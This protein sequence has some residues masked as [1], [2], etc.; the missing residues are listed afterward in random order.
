MDVFSP[1]WYALIV[2]GPEN[3]QGTIWNLQDSS[4]A[5]K[6]LQVWYNVT[7]LHRPLGTLKHNMYIVFIVITLTPLHSSQRQPGLLK[8]RPYTR[9]TL[10]TF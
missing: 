10:T 1:F 5:A 8:T 2:Y 9:L 3:V 7:I 4:L 6:M